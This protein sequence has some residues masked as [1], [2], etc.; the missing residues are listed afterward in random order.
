MEA[1]T[2]AVSSPADSRSHSAATWPALVAASCAE[3]MPY[4]FRIR[5]AVDMAARVRAAGSAIEA[6]KVRPATAVA[7]SCR[8]PVR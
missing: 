7:C 8:T 5:S 3:V 2:R 4:E 1:T 6:A